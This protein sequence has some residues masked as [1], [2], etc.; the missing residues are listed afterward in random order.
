MKGRVC[1]ATIKQ[2]SREQPILTKHTDTLALPLYFNLNI[3]NKMHK[4]YFTVPD[5]KCLSPEVHKLP[6]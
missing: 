3:V 2:V 6:L 5:Y 4:Q 1:G